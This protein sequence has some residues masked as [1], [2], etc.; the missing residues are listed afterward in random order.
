MSHPR[1]SDKRNASGWSPRSASEQVS[2]WRRHDHA[3]TTRLGSNAESIGADD[4][5]VTVFSDLMDAKSLFL[6]ANADTVYY[7]SVV[8]LTKGP[9]VVEQPPLGLG[10][11]NDMWFSWLVDIVL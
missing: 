5:S 8:S 9:M 7:M 11:I 6:T 1:R 3:R 2:R 10:T 4:N